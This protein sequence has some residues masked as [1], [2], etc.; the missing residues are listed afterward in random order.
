MLEISNGQPEPSKKARNTTSIDDRMRD[1]QVMTTGYV[2][3]TVKD[4]NKLP[5]YNGL[6]QDLSPSTLVTRDVCPDFNRINALTFRDYVMR[7]TPIH[8]K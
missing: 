3:K 2:V 4:L 1:T 5:S 7:I 8:S 6:S